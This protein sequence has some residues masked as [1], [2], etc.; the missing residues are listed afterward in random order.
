MNGP[1]AA[2]H[3]AGTSI[4]FSRVPVLRT[5]ATLEPGTV[6]ALDGENGAGKSTSMKV[7]SSQYC[8][9][10]RVIEVDGMHLPVGNIQAATHLVVAIIPE[11]SRPSWHGRLRAPSH[12]ARR[13]GP[14]VERGQYSLARPLRRRDARGILRGRAL[15]WGYRPPRGPGPRFQACLWA[16]NQHRKGAIV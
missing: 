3:C 6:T 1:V 16:G 12:R 11:S 4:C 8:A 5:S 7:A 14:V 2:M 9:D 10:S 15:T 13:P